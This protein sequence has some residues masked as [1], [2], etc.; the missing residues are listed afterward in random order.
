M[1][2]SDKLSLSDHGGSS[3]KPEPAPTLFVLSALGGSLLY[4][5]LYL[6]MLRIK[7]IRS[8][9]QHAGEEALLALEVALAALTIA[10]T[11]TGVLFLSRYRTVGG[12]FLTIAA[13]V[14][15]AVLGIATAMVVG[16]DTSTRSLEAFYVV[17]QIAGVVSVFASN[18]M[19]FYTRLPSM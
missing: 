5:V 12:R 8:L 9:P 3:N 13:I 2:A 14:G 7:F 11:I 4:S 6:G 1:T 17:G 19:A 15:L 18:Y 10:M 16:R